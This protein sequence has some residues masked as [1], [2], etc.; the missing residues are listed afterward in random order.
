MIGLAKGAATSNDLAR[1]AN[2]ETMDAKAVCAVEENYIAQSV[3]LVRMNL[4]HVTICN[5]RKLTATLR[6]K[7]TAR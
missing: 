2:D 7:R 5:R 4:Q 1:C 3:I 6:A